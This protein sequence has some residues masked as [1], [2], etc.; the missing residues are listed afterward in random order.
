MVTRRSVIASTGIVC[1][2]AFSGCLDSGGGESSSNSGS[3]THQESCRTV[4]RTH[5]ENLADELE[6][7]SAGATW[8]WRFDLEEGQRLIMSARMVDGARPALEVENPSG[9][10]VVDIGPSERIQRTLTAREDGRY[11][12]QFKNEAA[13]T[14]G[15]WDVQIDWEADYEEEVCD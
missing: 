9:A 13:I 14:R 1:M 12:V 10:T 6:T 8:T 11:F 2:G 4:E 15:Q 5:E 3:T 7:V